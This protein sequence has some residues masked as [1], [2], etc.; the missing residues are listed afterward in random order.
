MRDPEGCAHPLGN[1]DEETPGD[2]TF[3]PS[4]PRPSGATPAW[5]HTPWAPNL[6]SWKQPQT[7]LRLVEDSGASHGHL[8][9]RGWP[10]LVQ[11]AGWPVGREVRSSWEL[12]GITS[13]HGEGLEMVQDGQTEARRAGRAGRAPG[14]Q[15]L[16]YRA[17]QEGFTPT[18]QTVPGRLGSQLSPS[19]R[20]R[21]GTW[22]GRRLRGGCARRAQ[23]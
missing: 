21:P 17:H 1:G 2:L 19:S 12:S 20:A 9:R 13:R 7:C 4:S 3:R 5:T 6:W 22:Q 16:P 11:W 23:S 15:Q 18:C 10:G 14:K 8:G